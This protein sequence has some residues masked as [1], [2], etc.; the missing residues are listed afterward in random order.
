VSYGVDDKDVASELTAATIELTIGANLTFGGESV[1]VLA[2]IVKG[3][4]QLIVKLFYF[5][6]MNKCINSRLATFI[7][8]FN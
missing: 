7:L 6:Y 5:I 1:I 4:R 3:Y 8:H 2:G